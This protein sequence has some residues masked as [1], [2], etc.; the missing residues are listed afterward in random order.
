MN[1]RQA[2]ASV[3]YNGKRIDTKLAEYLQSFSYTDVASG[4]SD[5][6]SLSINDRDRKWIRSW[7]PSKGDTMAATIIM[8]SWNR[9]GDTKRLNCGAF[10]IDDFSFSGTPIKLKLEALALPTDSSFKETSRT[11]TYEN[12]TLENIGQEIAG[13]AGIQLYYEA[14]TISIEK[15]EQSEKDDCSFYNELVKLYGF[16]MK[17]YKSKIVVF[18]EATYEKRK[19]VATLTEQ[20]IE[21]NWSWNT[22]LCKTYTGAHYEYTNND[23]NQTITVDVGGG[24]RILKV[25]DAASNAAEAERITLAKVN[26]AN[27]S[28]TTMSVT[29]TMANRSI[30]ATSCVT[31]S[32][33]GKL[34]GKYYVEKVTWD[35]GSGCKQKLELR[36][37]SDRFTD[38]KS[39][40]KAV[41][42]E[43]KTETSTAT[44]TA[45]TA[46]TSDAVQT[47]VKGGK[48]TL[49]TTKKGYYTAAEALAGK[50]TGGHPTG[51]RRPGTYTIFNISQGMLNLTTKAGVPGSWINPN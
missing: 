3:T 8:K 49:T 12:T 5:S 23:K 29:L 20:N 2:T 35:I 1:P 41:A 51:T 32:G 17:I 13:R 45:T 31:I 4:E 34:N 14:P 18:S 42:K 7:F 9:D 22:K 30:I 36:K 24:N 33:L 48:Y 46:T 16:A 43:S 6:L 50:V 38:A 26:E 37:V 27:K 47:P 10:A 28:D 39:S 19:S 15:V 11:K 21:P 40:T 25:T 44:A